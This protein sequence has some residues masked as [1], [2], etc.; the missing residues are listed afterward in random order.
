MSSSLEIVKLFGVFSLII[1][2]KGQIETILGECT[3]S[4]TK[5]K[6]KNFNKKNPK[7]LTGL[8]L[9][10]KVSKLDFVFGDLNAPNAL[11]DLRKFVFKL[12]WAFICLTAILF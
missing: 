12:T 8:S 5:L 7:Q 4:K 6:N 2:K 1:K 9:R 10:E 3:G 11:L